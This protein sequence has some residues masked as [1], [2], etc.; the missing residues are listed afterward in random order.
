[1]NSK[2]RF[3]R[4]Q[5]ILREHVSF[6]N[7]LLMTISIGMIGFLLLLIDKPEFCL[8]FY[9]KIFFTSGLILIFFSVLLGFGVAFS[10]LL[11]F[12]ITVKKIKKENED[13]TQSE[14]TDLKNLM[15][16]YGKTTWNLFYFQIG[17]ICVGTT[18]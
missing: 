12:R 17:S 7:S 4:W 16:F 9:Q 1:M 14:L 18:A 13:S 8:T 11:D 3:V 2:D 10:R 5:G 15:N 6:L